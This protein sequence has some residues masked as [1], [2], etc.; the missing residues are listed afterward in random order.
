MLFTSKTIAQSLH[1]TP[2]MT[3]G[4][5]AQPALQCRLAA[6]MATSASYQTNSNTSTTTNPGIHPKTAHKSDLDSLL[7]IPTQSTFP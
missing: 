1:P 2:G 4:R 6:P 5:I 3:A 7:W